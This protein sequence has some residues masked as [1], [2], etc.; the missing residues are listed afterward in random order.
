MTH[1]STQ[2]LDGIS[3]CESSAA[4]LHADVHCSYATT[5]GQQIIPAVHIATGAC[6]NRRAAS[7]R[8][9]SAASLRRPAAPEAPSDVSTTLSSCSAQL[10]LEMQTMGAVYTDFQSCVNFLK[11]ELNGDADVRA[12]AAIM[13]GFEARKRTLDF[14][15]GLDFSVLC[16]FT[17]AVLLQFHPE[18]W[19]QY[20]NFQPIFAGTP[21]CRQALIAHDTKFMLALTCWDPKYCS[22]PHHQCGS[23]C[24]IK[25]LEG[26]L[27][28]SH[29]NVVRGASPA[30]DSAIEH[31]EQSD[32]STEYVLDLTRTATM[33]NASV[34]FVAG[35]AVHSI[36]NISDQLT[37]SLHLYVPP[38]SGLFCYRS[39]FNQDKRTRDIP[40]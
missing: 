40:R 26:N 31:A 22:P 36:E 25:V 4:L 23:K 1:R 33:S 21:A 20:S 3:L 9:S 16:L 13:R 27:S 12:T 15:H 24:W 34:T 14:S 29:F 30:A 17:D 11:S 6:W 28:E 18:E 2:L 10:K 19:R 8:T 37:Y 38:R 7:P 35:L 39:D 5:S 32:K